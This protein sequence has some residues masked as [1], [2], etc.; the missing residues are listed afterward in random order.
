MTMKKGGNDI[1]KKDWNA[2]KTVQDSG[3]YNMFSPEA[4]RASGLDKETYMV[5]VANYSDLE[6]KYEGE[7]T[8]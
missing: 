3:L 8:D 4:M 1:T 2:Y 5:V 7:E 6:D